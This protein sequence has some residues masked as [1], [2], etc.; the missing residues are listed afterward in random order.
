MS[1]NETP[2][3]KLVIPDNAVVVIVGFSKCP[4]FIRAV[5][6]FNLLEAA[7][8]GALRGAYWQSDRDAYHAIRPSYLAQLNKEADS[9]KTSP[10]VFLADPQTLQPQ[11]YVGGA[12]DFCTIVKEQYGV[13][14]AVLVKHH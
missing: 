3:P 10:L 14:P 4:N 2:E 12:S 7:K 5:E 13:E 9:H 8:P 11:V 6:T 1:T